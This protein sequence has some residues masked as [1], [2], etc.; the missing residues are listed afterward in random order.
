MAKS[1]TKLSE[2][3]ALLRTGDILKNYEYFEALVTQIFGLF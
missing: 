3:V 1:M 2:E